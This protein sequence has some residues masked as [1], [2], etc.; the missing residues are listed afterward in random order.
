MKILFCWH[1]FPAGFALIAMRFDS[2]VRGT[3][4]IGKMAFNSDESSFLVVIP[5]YDVFLSQEQV[6]L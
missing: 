1:C 6:Y 3:L 2:V 5:M 4:V